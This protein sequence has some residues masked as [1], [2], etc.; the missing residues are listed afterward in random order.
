MT[1]AETAST[2]CETLIKEAALVDADGG[3]ATLHLEQSLQGACQIVVDI[4]SRF[5]FEGALFA[6]R[7]ERGAVGGRVERMMLE[8]QERTYGDGLAQGDAAPVHVGSERALL[9]PGDGRS[10]TSLISLAP[11]WAWALCRVSPRP[12]DDFPIGMTGC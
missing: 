2:Y 5:E 11:L 8:A 7:R 12:G 3:R 1:L 9:Q 6:A 4:L 10:T